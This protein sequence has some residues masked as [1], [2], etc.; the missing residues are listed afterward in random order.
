[1]QTFVGM[2]LGALLLGFGV[3]IYDSMQTSEVANG[4]T[5]AASD[6][7]DSTVLY[8][9]V[10]LVAANNVFPHVPDIR[11]FAAGLRA[12]VRDSGL[13]TLEFPHL[14]RLIEG[15][16]YDTIYHEH[17]SYFSFTTTQ[18][19]FAAHGLTLFDV[20][21]LTTH[22]G[23]LRVYARHAAD[24][25]RAVGPRVAEM[26]AREA[27]AGL[28]RLDAYASFA[29]QVKETK[30]KLLTFLIRARREG[31]SVVGYGAPGKGNTL[32]NYCGIRSDFLD[33]TVYRSPHKQGLLT[34]G[35]HIPV[36]GP[37]RLLRDRPDVLLVLAWNFADEIVRQ[38]AEYARRGGCFLLPI[39]LAHYRRLAGRPAQSAVSSA[40][41]A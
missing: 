18:R 1:M 5:A 31:K 14:L 8:V 27:E 20:E 41:S 21:E 9:S 33:Y 3:Y 19:V 12:L 26:L 23:S 13:V 16:Q 32:L 7:P 39:P 2:I 4:Q 25:S 10:D 15:R 37:E 24:A 40:N 29:E 38:Q 22:G 34:P 30:R 35:H 11:G 36:D 6:L 28:N 17:F